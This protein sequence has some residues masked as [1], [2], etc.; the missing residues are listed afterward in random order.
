MF[1]HLTNPFKMTD[2]EIGNKKLTLSGDTHTMFMFEIAAL[3]LTVLYFLL[4]VIMAWTRNQVL[5][6]KVPQQYLVKGYSH[7]QI[8]TLLLLCLF[9]VIIAHKVGISTPHKEILGKHSYCNQQTC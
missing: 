6:K 8:W 1:D 2:R 5:W 3:Q 7:K 9:L 4:E